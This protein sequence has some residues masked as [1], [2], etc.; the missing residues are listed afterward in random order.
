MFIIPRMI[1]P[2]TM[3]VAFYLLTQTNK[4]NMNIVKRRPFHYKKKIC[5]WIIKNNRDVA[6]ISMDEL[7]DTVIDLAN[8]IIHFNPH[9]S[10]YLLIYSILLIIIIIL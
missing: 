1:E 10:L 3:S 7:G 6:E 8:N 2:T 5:K 4:M 9:P